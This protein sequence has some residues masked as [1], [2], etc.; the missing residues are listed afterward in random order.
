MSFPFASK[1]RLI[2]FATVAVRALRDH[3]VKPIASASTASSYSIF[4]RL[5]ASFAVCR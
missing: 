5:V 1:S 3:F 4:I 2:P